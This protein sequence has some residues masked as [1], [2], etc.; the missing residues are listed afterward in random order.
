[1]LTWQSLQPEACPPVPLDPNEAV[2]GLG[3]LPG[4]DVRYSSSQDRESIWHGVARG[5]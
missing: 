4:G 3:P 2:P 1:M 5:G